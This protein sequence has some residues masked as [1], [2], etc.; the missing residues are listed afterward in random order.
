MSLGPITKVTE[1]YYL[2]TILNI[3]IDRDGKIDFVTPEVCSS[4]QWQCL[5]DNISCPGIIKLA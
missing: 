3:H 5:P 2:L 4:F 1:V